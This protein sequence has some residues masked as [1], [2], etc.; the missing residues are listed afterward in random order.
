MS[1]FDILGGNRSGGRVSPIG[2]A[3]LGTLAY[4]ALKHRGQLT[5]VL[6]GR[7]SGTSPAGPTTNFNPPAPASGG[8]LSALG[9]GGGLATGLRDLLD[10]FRQSGHEDK[11][12]SWVATGAN[13]P[14][15]PGELEQ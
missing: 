5:E 4:Q 15:A 10:R 12:K 11:A 1:M 2:L 6:G 8:I 13:N 9:G 14:I 7:Q 3:V